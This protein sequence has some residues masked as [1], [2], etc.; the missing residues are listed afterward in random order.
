MNNPGYLLYSIAP[1]IKN[2][3]LYTL[4]FQDSVS[5]SKCYYHKIIIVINKKWTETFGEDGYIYGI[6]FGDGFMVVYLSPNSSSFI[7]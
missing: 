1:I 5:Y 3:I 4:K 7:H 6:Y 2:T